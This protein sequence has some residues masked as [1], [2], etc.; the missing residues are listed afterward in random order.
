MRLAALAV[1]AAALAAPRLAEAGGYAALVPPIE[2][3][4]GGAVSSSPGHLAVAEPQLML[5]VSWASLYPEKTPFDASVGLILLGSGEDEPPPGAAAAR[6]APPT[7]TQRAGTFVSF[8]ARALEGS[9]WRTFVGARAE[10][11]YFG[12]D[13]S[14]V[15]GFARVS[16]ELWMPVAGSDRN[17]VY[18]GTLG[19]SVWAEVGRRDMPDRARASVFAAGMGLRIPFAFVAG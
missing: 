8:E 1:L 12:A 2:L 14:G 5:A 16:G 7:P 15:G 9:H 19:L 6:S 4:M 10:K 11:F 17:G 13:N 18:F 3:E